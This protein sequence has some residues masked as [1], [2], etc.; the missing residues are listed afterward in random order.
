MDDL[1][2]KTHVYSAVKALDP[3][4]KVSK[5]WFAAL[6]SHV[7]RVIA[8]NVKATKAGG[9]V[10]LKSFVAATATQTGGE[11]TQT[12]VAEST[13]ESKCTMTAIGQRMRRV[14]I[15]YKASVTSPVG[16][17]CTIDGTLTVHTSLKGEPLAT[18]L[19][20]LAYRR[21]YEAGVDGIKNVEIVNTEE[22]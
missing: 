8:A 21:L 22:V 7:Q 15:V 10:T 16:H 2:I 4:V 5:G 14:K 6:N 9:H 19:K 3:D 17:D 20:R 11:E 13:G 18:M 12:P 1:L